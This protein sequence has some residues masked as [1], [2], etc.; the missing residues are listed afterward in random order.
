MNNDPTLSVSENTRK[1]VIEIENELK[2][3]PLRK[4]SEKTDKSIETFNVGL[5]ML[6][7]EP[8]DPYYQSIRLGVESTCNPYS[9]NIATTMIAGKSHKLVIDYPVGLFIR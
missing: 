2:Y 1:R 8:I 4:K 5:I 7:D 6:N 9:L 3:K